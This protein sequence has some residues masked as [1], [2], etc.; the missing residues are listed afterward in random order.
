MPAVQPPQQLWA[1]GWK[2][3]ITDFLNR[4]S[5][6]GIPN[7]VT[8]TSWFRSPEENRRVGGHEWSNHLLALGADGEHRDLGELYRWAERARAQG[9]VAVVELGP[10]RGSENWPFDLSAPANENR[11]LHLQRRHVDG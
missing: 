5:R 9:L 4:I 3:W 1:S 7:G 8:W 11:H 6:S 10:A 2:P